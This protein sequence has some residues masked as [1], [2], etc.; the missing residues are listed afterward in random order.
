M[1]GEVIHL[2]NDHLSLQWYQDQTGNY[3]WLYAGVKTRDGVVLPQFRSSNMLDNE[4]RLAVMPSLGA[5]WFYQTGV[6]MARRSQS[7]KGY[8]DRA[9][10][11]ISHDGMVFKFHE[12]DMGVILTQSFHFV[13]D[14]TCVAAH[15]QLDNGGDHAVDC[16]WLASLTLPLA[17]TVK[18]MLSLNGRH[19]KEFQTE[20]QELAMGTVVRENRRGRTS[21]DKPPSLMFSEFCGQ[22]AEHN[23]R[24]AAVHLAWSG[25]NRLVVDRGDGQY[26]VQAGEL[27]NQPL[28]IAAGASYTTPTAY[29]TF[30]NQGLNGASQNFHALTR[31]IMPQLSRPRPALLNSWEAIYFDH[32]AERLRQLVDSA[33]ALGVERFVLDDGWFH[34]RRNDTAGLGDWWVDRAVYPQG[35]GWLIDL[36]HE[37]NMEF[38]L[39]IEPEMVNPNSDL[40]QNHPDFALAAG[41][42]LVTGRNQMVLDF[43]NPTVFD[44]IYQKISKILSDHAIDFIKWDMNRDIAPSISPNLGLDVAHQQTLAVYRL[45]E[46]LTRDFPKIEFESCSSGGGRVDLGILRYAARV[47]TSDCNDAHERLTIQS[48]FLRFFPPEI[49]GAHVGPSPAHT[50]GRQHSMRFRC[51]VAFFG[52]FGLEQR[53][54]EVS[55]HDQAVLRFWLDAYKSKRHLIHGQKL[56]QTHNGDGVMAWISHNASEKSGIIGI[57]RDAGNN[58]TYPPPV[59]LPMMRDWGKIKFRVIEDRPQDNSDK[60]VHATDATWRQALEHISISSRFL[61]DHGLILPQMPPDTAIMLQYEEELVA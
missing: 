42:R 29:F 34:G 12:D 61:A 17:V 60:I 31:R 57:Y 7:F 51:Q 18:H 58:F 2:S 54:D 46:K 22:G 55:A 47:W 10:H 39:W 49:M 40:Y 32:A 14:G 6:K 24:V 4:P 50:T 48:G 28:E 33:A 25:N 36:V 5:G 11:E 26:F 19:L 3:N 20:W 13:G 52:H 44:D 43:A 38:G 59:L 16:D 27:F 15:C 8:F 37:K 56:W 1:R 21:F 53:V 9:S 30:S 45:W 23:G 41:P 35:L